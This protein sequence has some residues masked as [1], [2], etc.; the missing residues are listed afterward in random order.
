[1]IAVSP[2]GDVGIWST[3]RTDTTRK[4]QDM[5]HFLI[6]TA[7]ERHSPSFWPLHPEET[8]SDDSALESIEEE[9][10][11]LKRMVVSL[12]EIILESV[13]GKK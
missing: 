10:R 2:H 4:K 1:M 11:L 7:T 13:V 6:N 5:A 3:L 9:N 8:T 12:S